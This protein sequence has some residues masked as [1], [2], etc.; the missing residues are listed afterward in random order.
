[1]QPDP[2]IFLSA[3][4]QEVLNPELFGKGLAEG[5]SPLIMHRTGETL[6]QLALRYT[7]L[8]HI[9]RDA[10]PA[11]MALMETVQQRFTEL[12]A[13]VAPALTC[14]RTNL[15]N[16]PGEQDIRAFE[17]WTGAVSKCIAFLSSHQSEREDIAPFLADFRRAASSL[18]LQVRTRYKAELEM[19]KNALSDAS[20]PS[21][22]AQ[23]SD[24][25]L[26]AVLRERFP[27]FANIEARNISRL[28][29][30]TAKETFWHLSP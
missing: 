14:Y 19:I 3:M 26:T 18:E 22:H 13:V 8:P 20:A 17:V 16:A 10:R 6:A 27:A 21:G 29:G 12:E 11:Q 30:V 24:A 5:L 9:L 23:P 7:R 15:A 25:E 4:R 28:P 1:M 2:L